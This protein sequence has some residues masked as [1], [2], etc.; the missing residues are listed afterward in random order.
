MILQ[1]FSPPRAASSIRIHWDLGMGEHWTAL[2]RARARAFWHG[3]HWHM[4]LAEILV[5]AHTGMGTGTGILAGT[6]ILLRYWHG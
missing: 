5:R 4:H 3:W 6:V 2:E 1:L